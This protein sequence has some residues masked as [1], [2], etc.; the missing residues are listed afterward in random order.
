M[1]IWTRV[2]KKSQSQTL[3]PASV[4]FHGGELP[5]FVF[6]VVGS[7]FVAKENESRVGYKTITVKA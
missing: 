4:V 5:A 7:D 2:R 6:K 3:F 1:K